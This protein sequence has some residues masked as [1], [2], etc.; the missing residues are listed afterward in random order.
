MQLSIYHPSHTEGYCAMF[1]IINLI[2]VF[3]TKGKSKDRNY[4]CVLV[5]FIDVALMESYLE[6]LNSVTRID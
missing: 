4:H 3:T 6:V 5:V 2:K 1:W